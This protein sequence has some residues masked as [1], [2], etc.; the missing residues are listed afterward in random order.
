MKNLAKKIFGDHKHIVLAVKM[1]NDIKADHFPQ[2]NDKTSLGST[3][4]AHELNY[5]FGYGRF[6]YQLIC[7]YFPG[8]DILLIEKAEMK[9]RK[10]KGNSSPD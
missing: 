10:F 4:Y 1:L 9:I 2:L 6:K 7:D 8:N 3:T 5:S